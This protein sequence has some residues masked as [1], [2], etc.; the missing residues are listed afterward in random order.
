MKGKRQNQLTDEHIA[1]IIDTYQFRKEAERYSRLDAGFL[2]RRMESC[3]LPSRIQPAS[4]PANDSEL[5]S[6]SSL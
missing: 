1:R 2:P 4:G 6:Q 5:S 3:G